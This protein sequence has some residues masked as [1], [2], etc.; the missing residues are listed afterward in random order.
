MAIVLTAIPTGIL[1]VLLALGL[2]QSTLSLNSAL[3][4]ILLNGIAVANSIIMVD[5][6]RVMIAK[7]H[8]PKEA[9]IWAS[10]KRLR[11]ILITSLT[12][13]LGMLPIALGL[14]E[15]GKVLQPLGLAVA[16]GL[17]FSM[18]FTLYIVPALEYSFYKRY[19]PKRLESPHEELTQNTSEAIVQEQLQ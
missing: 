7:G 8:A 3:G 15:G 1:G 2:F 16:G 13:I 11:P 17:W 19:P 14:G 10:V 12:T 5:F 4:I 6:I 9:A 18:L